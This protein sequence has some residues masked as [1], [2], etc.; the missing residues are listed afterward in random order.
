[1]QVLFSKTNFGTCNVRSEHNAKI[2]QSRNLALSVYFKL[3]KTVLKTAGL[4]DS[5]NPR[6]FIRLQTIKKG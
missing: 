6:T 1:M 5:R 3:M 4:C 2:N